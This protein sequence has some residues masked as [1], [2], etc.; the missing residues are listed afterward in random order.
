MKLALFGA[1]GGTGQQLL[2]QAL[3]A[4]HH[5]TAIVRDPTRLRPAGPPRA[6]R[7]DR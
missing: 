4:G 7:G 5:V 1:T 3:A 6:R 2:D